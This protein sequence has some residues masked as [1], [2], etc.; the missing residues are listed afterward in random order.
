MRAIAVVSAGIV[1]SEEATFR[2]GFI[3]VSVG[4]TFHEAVKVGGGITR[5]GGKQVGTSPALAITLATLKN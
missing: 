2:Q 5:V 3:W 4:L 1:M